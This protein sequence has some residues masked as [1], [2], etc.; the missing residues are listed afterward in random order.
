MIEAERY[1]RPGSK[2][3]SVRGR[4]ARAVAA[5]VR[6][7]VADYQRQRCLPALL[8][9]LPSEIADASDATLRRIVVRLARALRAERRRG[10]AGHWSYDINRHIAL[11]QAYEAERG[12]LRETRR[13]APD[14][15]KGPGAGRTL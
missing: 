13:T 3:V 6:A 5:T 4:A 8:P 7:G 1:E 2:P 10:R 9:M 11:L 15:E 14:K 12:L